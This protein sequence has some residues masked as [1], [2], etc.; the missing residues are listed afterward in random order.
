MLNTLDTR[1]EKHYNMLGQANN[2]VPV[3]YE[4]IEDIEYAKKVR[5]FERGLTE[6]R[7]E[8]REKDRLVYIPPYGSKFE[9]DSKIEETLR[10]IK[11]YNA[12]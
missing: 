2:T 5:A 8:P 9:L 7:P 1:I 6:F 11:P 12:E 3:N 4:L 10:S